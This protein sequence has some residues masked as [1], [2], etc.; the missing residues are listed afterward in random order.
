MS[1][2][3][4]PYIERENFDSGELYKFF[5]DNLIGRKIT[6]ITHESIKLENG[7]A[8]K[9]HPNYGCDCGKG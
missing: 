5:K 3:K 8:I 4:Y 1:S 9:I 7:Y 6:E 2:E